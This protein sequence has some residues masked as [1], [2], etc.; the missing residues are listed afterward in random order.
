MRKN[1]LGNAK[2]NR[3]NRSMISSGVS[4]LTKEELRTLAEFGALNCFAEH[5]RAAMW[6]VEEHMHRSAICCVL[7]SGAKRSRGISRTARGRSLDS[8]RD[9]RTKESPLLPM[10]MPERVKADYDGMN[11]TTGPHP[12]KLVARKI[13]RI[14][15]ARLISVR[16][17]RHRLCRLPAMSFAVS[18]PGQRKDLSLSAWRTR[19]AFP[20]RSLRRIYSSNCG[21]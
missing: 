9:D 19:P 20:M 17:A 6:E 5:R 12:M 10:T 21:S 16:R 8:A 4:A 2:H 18:G 1:S 3:F 13:C 11:L 15:G 7:P 14:S